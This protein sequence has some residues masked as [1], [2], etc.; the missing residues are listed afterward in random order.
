MRASDITLATV[1]GLL[2]ASGVRRAEHAHVDATRAEIMRLVQR[3]RRRATNA[4][5]FVGVVIGGV[6]LGYVAARI[7]R[8]MRAGPQPAADAP[9]GADPAIARIG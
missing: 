9:E 1:G 8:D 4:E 2:V 6:V 3:V 5:S 7:L